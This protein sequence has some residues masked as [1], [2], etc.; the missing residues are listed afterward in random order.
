MKNRLRKINK[1]RFSSDWFKLEKCVDLPSRICQY[2]WCIFLKEAKS[3]IKRQSL[4]K[5]VKRK[6]ARFKSNDTKS[7]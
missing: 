6:S 3:I 7:N 4:L 5:R 1:Y 2:S